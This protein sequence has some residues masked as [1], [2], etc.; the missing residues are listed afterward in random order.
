MGQMDGVKTKELTS[1]IYFRSMSLPDCWLLLP[2]IL[3]HD[4]QPW[5]QGFT[6]LTFLP[7]A[8][9]DDIFALI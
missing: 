9:T 6:K 5:D 1:G 7:K 4:N 3:G 2:A 8:S